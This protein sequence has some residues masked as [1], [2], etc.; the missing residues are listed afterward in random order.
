M[1]LPRHNLNID[2]MVINFAF[3]EISSI[4]F[5][6]NSNTPATESDILNA[7]FICGDPLNQDENL[8]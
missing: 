7:S 3:L 1:Q 5:F 4:K 8:I 6:T 2:L